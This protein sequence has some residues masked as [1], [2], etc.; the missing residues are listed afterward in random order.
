[1]LDKN[2]YTNILGLISRC[3][4]TGQEATIVAILQQKIGELLKPVGKKD[5][6]KEKPQ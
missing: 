1:M 2:D 3:N 6:G 5:E 4:I